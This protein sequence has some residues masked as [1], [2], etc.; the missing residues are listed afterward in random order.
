MT[1]RAEQQRERRL[2]AKLEAE[3]RARRDRLTRFAVVAGLLAVAAASIIV[4]AAT[5]DGDDASPE[6]SAAALL[7]TEP[8]W[9]PQSRGFA[10]RV[11]ALAFPPVGDES[12]HAHT[13]L[14][15]FRDGKQVEVPN[16]I[17]FDLIGGGH[18]PLHTHDAKGVI[19]ME[20]D[21]PYPYKLSNVFTV[22]GVAFDS[23]RLG[24]DVPQGDKK[25]HIYVNGKPAGP[26]APLADGDNIVVAYGTDGSFPKTPNADAL[27]T[28]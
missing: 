10:E 1:S 28:A 22:W 18:A 15:V 20:S 26:D 11:D 23:G 2:A 12:Y 16:G 24:S 27:K 19:H 13:L 4:I 5:Q 6:P 21:D 14:S 17:G 8:P 9:A 25:V 7:T 3:R